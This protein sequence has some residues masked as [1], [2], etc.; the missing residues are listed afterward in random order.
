MSL[1]PERNNTEN[2]AN[3]QPVIRKLQVFD[4]D[5]RRIVEKRLDGNSVL[6]IH[7]M[8][9]LKY[10]TVNTIIK[11][12]EKTGLVLPCKRG[13]DRRSKLSLEVKISLLH[14]GDEECTLTLPNLKTLLA[15]EHS[16]RRCI[17]IYYTQSSKG[18]SLYSKKSYPCT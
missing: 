11:R 15:S 1:E 16:V 14:H 5:R 12:F 4:E 17:Y 6:N 18:I 13:G 8:L 9:G 10:Q 3:N 7:K 2:S